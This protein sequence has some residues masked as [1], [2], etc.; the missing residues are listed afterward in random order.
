LRL[1]VLTI[2]AF[3]LASLAAA[4]A[5]PP[6]G[7]NVVVAKLYKDFAWEAVPGHAEKP[8]LI[9][10]PR[11]VL[12]RYF[13][14]TL[15]ALILEDRK[16]VER[17]KEV[18]RLDFAPIWDSQDPAATRVN[19]LGTS[20]PAVVRVTFTDPGNGRSTTLS[21]RTAKTRDGWRIHDID[22]TSH[23]SLLSILRAKM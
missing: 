14:D 15:T 18:C 13:D 6:P 19:V 7:A 9:E 17:T 21:Y 20:D 11:A 5:P 23:E 12:S 2:L 16:C 22:Y 4:P 10:Q 1:S 8:G 3:S